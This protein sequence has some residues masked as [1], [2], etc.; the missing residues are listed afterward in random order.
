MESRNSLQLSNYVPINFHN[1]FTWLSGASNTEDSQTSL[2][3]S[4]KL[5]P[6]PSTCVSTLTGIRIALS[7]L[8]GRD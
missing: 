4:L 7:L 5:C 3:P 8:P 2:P 1:I 6:H